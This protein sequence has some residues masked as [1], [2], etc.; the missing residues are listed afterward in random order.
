ME[1]W[2]EA[3]ADLS[4]AVEL[5]STDAADPES[6]RRLPEMYRSLGDVLDKMGRL[7]EAQEAFQKA[8]EVEEEVEIEK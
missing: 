6:R 2:D 3:I 1:R 4:K 8:Q 7:D 5:A